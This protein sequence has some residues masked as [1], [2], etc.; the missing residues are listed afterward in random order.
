MSTNMSGMRKPEVVSVA[1]AT[2][3]FSELIDRVM[4]GD[5]FVV[6]RRGR[7]VLAL[8]RPDE[9]APALGEPVGLAA[10]A[11]SLADWEELPAVVGQIYR[12]RRARDRAAPEPG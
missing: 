5:R 4:R 6:T 8:V 1:E 10:V 9:A 7:P 12:R 11:G 3:H 2:A